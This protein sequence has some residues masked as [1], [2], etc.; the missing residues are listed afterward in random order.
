MEPLPCIDFHGKAPYICLPAFVVVS[1]TS[2]RSSSFENVRPRAVSLL[3]ALAIAQLH[4]LTHSIYFRFLCHRIGLFH[5]NKQRMTRVWST[6]GPLELCT[7]AYFSK[8][9][10]GE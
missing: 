9:F 4:T 3:R 10:H 8:S 1:R 5:R 2:R 7:T 6:F